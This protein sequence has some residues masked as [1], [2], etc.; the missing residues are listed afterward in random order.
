MT[1]T[2]KNLLNTIKKILIKKSEG[3]FYHEEVCEYQVENS[4]KPNTILTTKNKKDGSSYAENSESIIQLNEED[5]FEQLKKNQE[6]E[7]KLTLLKK[8][9]TTHFVPPDLLAIKMLIENFGQEIEEKNDLSKLSNK[10][11]NNL[12]NKLI[13]ELK[14]QDLE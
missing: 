13:E 1:K 6:K 12:K 4:K 14:S 7:D 10:E 8:K 2:D 11:L 9:I 3:F 5:K